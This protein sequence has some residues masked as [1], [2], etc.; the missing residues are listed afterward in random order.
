MLRILH[1]RG[2]A[3]L[4]YV[5]ISQRLESVL[6]HHRHVHHVATHPLLHLVLLAHKS[7]KWRLPRQQPLNRDEWEAV[8]VY[9]FDCRSRR[10]EV[11]L[12]LVVDLLVEAEYVVLYLLSDF[13]ADAVL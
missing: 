4:A 5:D 13:Q 11:L 6:V 3:G 9:E 12:Q 2:G 7:L 8:E 1:L 10:F